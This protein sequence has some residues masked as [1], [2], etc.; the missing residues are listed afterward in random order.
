[1]KSGERRMSE[2]L[3]SILQEGNLSSES[4]PE[5]GLGVVQEF[6]ERVASDAEDSPKGVGVRINEA[7]AQLDGEISRQ[8]SEVMSHPDFQ[9]LEATWRGLSYLIQNSE[10]GARLKLRVLPANMAE[11]GKDL[12]QA[13]EFDQSQLF[14]KL[15]E[16]EYGTF[17]GLP[18]SMIVVDHEFTPSN[19]DM[20]LLENL[21][22][23][24][25]AAHA[26]L[27]SA[28]GAR[29]FGMNSFTSL[30][31]PRDMAK[32]F[33]ATDYVKWR[34]FRDTED[35]RYVTL[36][37]PRILLRLP[38][39]PEGRPVEELNY[40]EGIDGKDHDKYLW[41][42]AAW[43]LA[44]RV[45][46]AFALYGWTAAIRGVEGGGLVEGLPAFT[47]R[48]DEGDIALQCPTEIAIT[49]RREKE[50]S[51][52]GF[53]SLIHCKGTDKAAFFGGQ[54]VNQPKAY[55]TDDANANA[56]LSARL[57]YIFAASRFAH[58]FKVM[59]RDK[60]GSFQTAGQIQT[61][62]QTWISDYILLDDNASQ[63]AKAKFP[64]REARVDVREVPGSPGAFT[65]VAFL[66]PHFQLEEIS[67]S[68]RLVANL[69]PPA[70]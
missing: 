33:E 29:M 46:N 32:V 65:A 60:I 19:Q 42:N 36:T 12:A 21:A 4:L 30:G 52:L 1:M 53:I 57:P 13:V 47:F 37:L 43:A 66:R 39:G 48:S 24:A 10:T 5:Q 6:V 26:P 56:M 3:D 2:L 69:P 9:K 16:E 49:D 11:V 44:Q 41:G 50:L 58:Y 67:A 18:Y 34:S 51:D 14:K 22:S 59:L 70:A 45:T 20:A 25:A 31:N 62:L 7:I 64:L 27:I 8:L 15:Y 61:F 68:I 35:S 38:Y 40:V 63:T 23:V 55:N 28:A 54:T 17:G